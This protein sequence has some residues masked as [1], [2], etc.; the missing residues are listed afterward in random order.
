[1]PG[2]LYV[3][4]TPIGNLED[5]T[6]RALR[7]LREVDAVAAEDTRRTGRLLHHFGIDKPLVSYHDR[8]ERRKAPVLVE[9]L[10]QGKSL[11]LVSDAGTPLV[12][13]PGYRLVRAA[14]DAGIRV[15]PVPGPSAATTILSV[16]G[17]PCDRF[18]FEGFLPIKKGK[19]RERLERLRDETRTVIFYE[20]PHHIE[21]TLAEIEEIFGE[22]EIVV[23]R[24][25][26]KIFEEI[27]R[28]P[29]SA[30]RAALAGKP[31]RGE[32]TLAIAGALARK[33][34]ARIVDE[35]GLDRLLAEADF[36]K[37]GKHH[38]E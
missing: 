38:A 28:G 21:R 35:Q 17:L 33:E 30:V 2:T 27:V 26:T 22:R 6:E 23:G 13:D 34:A 29:I 5:I 11:A 7:I 37:L 9:E 18:V 1:M 15:V 31:P 8:T 20:S 16:S 3:V 12:S 19:R 14:I 24:E 32:Y 36:A 25:L 10:L 4:A